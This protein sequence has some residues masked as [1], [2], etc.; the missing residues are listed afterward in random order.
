VS[1]I[2]ETGQARKI[3]GAD[4]VSIKTPGLALLGITVARSLRDI[5]SAD[6]WRA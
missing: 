5:S 3:S 2:A 4:A 1:P 6:G